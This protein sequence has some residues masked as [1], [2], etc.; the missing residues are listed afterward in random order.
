[1]YKRVLVAVGDYPEADKPLEYA[2]ALAVHT[3]AELCLLRVLTVPIVS[4]SPDMVACSTL[5]ME[6]LME[7]NEH[8]LAY[9][10]EAA[11]QAH[12]PYIALLRWGAIPHAI[13]QTAEEAVCDLIVVGASVCPG[14]QRRCNGYITRKVAAQARQPVLVVGQAPPDRPGIS[15]W[16]RFLVVTGDAPGAEAATA[17]ALTLAQ[18]EDLDVCLLQSDITSP[19]F[20]SVG[21]AT[22]A[23]NALTL[24]AAWAA[25]AGVNYEVRHASGDVVTAIIETAARTQCD[26]IILGAHGSPGW[27]RFLYNRTVKLVVARSPLPVL[28]VNHSVLGVG[29]IEQS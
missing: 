19:V 1:M 22:R 20:A 6:S 8:V 2:I 7:A 29:Y 10:V 11:A 3:D 24:A 28:L 15:W 25:A 17:Y 12:V 23:H 13:V 26:A 16:R 21:A 5:A 4:G 27:K 14:W 18:E 9:A